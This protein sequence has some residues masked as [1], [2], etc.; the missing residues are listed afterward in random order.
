MKVHV[1]RKIIQE[2]ISRE[3]YISGRFYFRSFLFQVVSISGRFYFRSFLFQ[4]VSISG[5]FY[6]RSFLHQVVSISDRMFQCYLFQIFC[7]NCYIC[8]NIQCSVSFRYVV[9]YM[10][11]YSDVYICVNLN[12][13]YR[14]IKSLIFG[15]K[16][17]LGIQIC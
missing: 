4:V 5:R 16:L 12:M 8:L 15:L 10:P 3:L 11:A 6:F 14:S 1:Y 13:L 2:I 9:V 7:S 17:S